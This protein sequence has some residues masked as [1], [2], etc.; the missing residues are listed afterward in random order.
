ME[1]PVIRLLSLWPDRKAVHLDAAAA[2]PSLDPIAVHRWFKRKSIPV[3]HWPA[4]IDGARNRGFKLNAD[5]LL[6]A[7]SGSAQDAA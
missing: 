1:N 7:H 6:A 2:D 5:M 3:K 4:L